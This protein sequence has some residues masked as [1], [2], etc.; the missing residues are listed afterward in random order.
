MT[1]RSDFPFFPETQLFD[2]FYHFGYHF[3][4]GYV[5]RL[6]IR[7]EAVYTPDYSSTF[8]GRI[9]Q[10]YGLSVENRNF[11]TFSTGLST[12]VF[13]RDFHRVY[14]VSVNIIFETSGRQV[15]IFYTF[16]VLT[17]AYFF[18]RIWGIDNVF[19]WTCVFTGKYFE[20]N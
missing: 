10:I 1:D 2:R 19:P 18:C 8:P 4:F 6:T 20:K 12:R 16:S 7:Y 17:G 9:L 3:L 15:P 11:S 5:T 14:T 13:H